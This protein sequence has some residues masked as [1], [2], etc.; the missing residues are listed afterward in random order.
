M[1][2]PLTLT[3]QVVNEFVELDKLELTEATVV[4]DRLLHILYDTLKLLY[5][6]VTV[7]LYRALSGNQAADSELPALN[8]PRPRLI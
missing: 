5:Y 4:I 3:K 8:K 2:T 7:T 6:N 1:T